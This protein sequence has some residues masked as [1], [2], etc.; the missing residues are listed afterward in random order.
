MIHPNTELRF[1]SDAIGWGVVATRRIP[2]GTITWT[3]DDFDLVFTPD[4]VGEMRP[5]YREIVDRYSYLAPSGDYVLCWDFGRYI[6]HSCEP[7][8][9]S[10]GPDIEIALRDIEAGEQL[11]SDYGELNLQDALECR[12]GASRCRGEIRREDAL[13]LWREWDRTVQESI[14]FVRTVEQP[15]WRFLREPA[16]LEAILAG[17]LPVPSTRQHYLPAPHE[18]AE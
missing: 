17:E 5:A 1:I 11:T 2:R 14:P 6:N 9:R 12:C 13:A 18:P 4:R 8:S 16:R 10:L 3:L 15:L 7:T